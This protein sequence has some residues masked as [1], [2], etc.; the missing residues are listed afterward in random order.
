MDT[1]EK[2]YRQYKQDVYGYLLGLTHDPTLSEDLLSETFLTS[3]RALPTF[4]QNSTVKTWLCGIARNMWL[5][6]LRKLKPQVEYDD[7]LGLYITQS[8]EKNFINKQTVERI[9]TL[10]ETKDERT[11]RIVGMRVD[12]LAYSDCYNF[13][14]MPIVGGS[15]YLILK[16]KWVWTPLWI[17]VLS[18]V[19]LFIQNAFEGML[20]SGFTVE[21]FYIPLFYSGIY[22]GLTILG[23]VIV[24][25][26]KYAFRKEGTE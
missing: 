24:A 21:I 14:I 22:A 18:Y 13:L 25:L 26:L 19:W 7:L 8:I 12:G 3:I 1:I 20:S 23:V 15:G 2:L 16:K 10:L 6:H 11:R 4:K 9:Y 5:Q 17:F